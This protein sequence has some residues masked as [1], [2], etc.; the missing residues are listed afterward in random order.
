MQMADISY[1]TAA[2]ESTISIPS[3]VSTPPIC[4]PAS[5]L[6]YTPPS[7]QES[8]DEARPRGKYY[9]KYA[10]LSPEAKKKVY[11][12]GSNDRQRKGTIML[13]L[14]DDSWIQALGHLYFLK[15][16]KTYIPPAIHDRLIAL[17][18]ELSSEPSSCVMDSEFMA[19]HM[20]SVTL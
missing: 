20:N 10:K 17:T 6:T 2:P 18:R 3:F 5:I 12:K 13:R 19:T 1:P 9:S 7:S 11:K 16:G 14:L 15:T 4:L 8:K